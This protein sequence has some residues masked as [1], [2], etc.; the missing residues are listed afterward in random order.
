MF[1]SQGY[2]GLSTRREGA[3]TGRLT[4]FNLFGFEVRVHSSWIF[5]ALLVA[6]SLAMGYFPAL[7]EGL[8][9]F[10][11]W[12]MGVLG[13]VGLFVSIVVHEFFHS[14]VARYYQMQMKGITLFILGGIAEMGD[15]PPHPKAEGLMAVAGPLASVF[16]WVFFG[17]IA[18]WGQFL[19]W[20]EAVTA[21]IVYLS[22]I[23]LI[24]AIFNMI[25]AFPMDGGR[26]LRS[27]LWGIRGDIRWATRWASQLGSI[28]G[29]LLVVLGFFALFSGN[30]LPAVWYILLG[31]FIG[32]AARSSYIQ[33]ITRDTLKEE[34]LQRFIEPIEHPLAPEMS[35]QEALDQ[36]F[37]RFRQRMFP[38]VSEGRLLG[39]VNVQGIRQIP[40][41]KRAETTVQ[42]VL[43]ECRESDTILPTGNAWEAFRKMGQ[44]SSPELLVVQ[45]G[46]LQGRIRRQDLAEFL[47]LKMEIEEGKPVYS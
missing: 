6:W 43:K 3:A 1:L 38:V 32:F 29:L 23:N 12:V 31:V 42:E 37:Y 46:S 21:V 30:I 5:L 13:V 27:I 24:L 26:V 39:C 8:S 15:E 2:F 35:V 14:V 34:P 36:Y 7:Q 16:L 40:S 45:D 33:I 28:F 10:Q 41:G 19:N 4:L 44:S 25:P 20:P 9:T 11:Y 17:L 18:G 22:Q 47:N